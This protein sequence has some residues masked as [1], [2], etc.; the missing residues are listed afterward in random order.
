MKAAIYARVSTEEQVQNFSIE[1][2]L[3][4]LH[5]YCQQHDY[6]V[7][8]EYVDPGFSGTTLDRPALVKLLNH[9]KSRLFEVV[10]VY[11]L[12]RLFRSNR[13]MYNTLADWEELG[14]S[15]GSVTEPFD[16]TT[17]MGRAYLGMASTFAEW[18]RNTF[19]ERSRD[20]LRKAIDK[21]IYSGG[22]I[23]YGYRLRQDTKQLEIDEQEAKVVKDVFRWLVEDK[24]SCYSIAQRL[25]AFRIPTRYAKD[26]R[27]IK[28]KATASIWRPGR[29]YNMLRNTA[30]KGRWLYGKRGRKKQL[31]E[32]A[33]SSII[34]EATFEQAQIRLKQNNLWAD[35]NQRRQ[36]LLRGLIK[37]GVCGHSYTGYCSRTTH[38]G[39]LR[40]YRC[41]QNGNRAN[42]LS[43]RCDAPTIP[44]P[45][46][47]DLIWQQISEFIQNPKVVAEALKDRLDTYQ[48]ATCIADLAQARHRLGDLKEAERRL[49]RLYADPAENYSKESLDGALADVINNRQLVQKRIQELEEAIASE[50]EQRRKLA[51]VQE[52]L[53]TLQDRLQNV[54]SEAKQEV[55]RNLVSEI[56]IGKLDDGTPTLRIVFAFSKDQ[57][58]EPS[59][60]QL[61]SSRMPVRLLRRPL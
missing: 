29:V 43:A 32:V 59:G 58:D 42:L 54:T 6:Q 30:Y 9:A 47:E 60:V 38:N 22:I 48:Q 8:G 17:T 37:C 16:T 61:H 28:G 7:V 55:V 10:V 25:N 11:K 36:Y 34:D 23:A 13:H 39:E 1:N 20:G 33:C 21:G 31:I 26:K 52:I 50:D 40:Y 41:N 57:F 49:L 35:R 14:I 56:T 45:L 3:E 46:V 12:D 53:A 24:L 19:I 44:A 2:Q 4:Q 51:D 5:K 27:G 15:L 18:E